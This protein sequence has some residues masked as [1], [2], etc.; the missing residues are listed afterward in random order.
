MKENSHFDKKSLKIIQG[1][2]ASWSELAKDCVCFANGVGGE[3]HIGV[4]DDKDFPASEQIITTEMVE[5]ISKRIPA[6]TLNV[7]IAPSIETAE[8]GGQYINLRVL[9]SKQTV[10]ST[11]DGRYYMRVS[12][13]CKPILPDE[14][15]RLAAEKDAFVWEEK[16]F[17]KIAFTDKDEAKYKVFLTDVLE[18]ERVSG[19][20]KEMSGEEIAEHYF[21]Q[22][23]GF[24]TNLGIL[25]LGKRNQ[26]ATLHYAP[27]IQFIK[28]NSDEKKIFKKV[29]DDY[30]L[31]PKELIN[32]IINSI[33]D[34]NEFIEVS[35]GIFRRNIYHYHPEVIRELFANALAHRN[36]TMR[37]DIF[38]NLYTDKLEIHSPG[39]LPLG[40]TPANILTK[41]VQRNTLLA[42]LMYDLKLME[43]EGS[44]YDKVYELLLGNAKGLPEVI[45]G[46]DRVIVTLKKEILDM[47]VL[48]LMDKTTKELQLRQREL[49]CLGLIAQKGGLHAIELA[50]HLGTLKPNALTSWLGRLLE[51]KILLSKGKTKATL[52]YVNP[53]FLKKADFIE[54]TNLKRIE[55]H[56]LKALIYE[57]LKRYPA[58]SKGEIHKRI[59]VDD[60]KERA[61]KLRLDEMIDSGVIY[62]EGEKK[63][64]K[65]FINK[66][67]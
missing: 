46:D 21:L 64:T 30:S 20:V 65:Y 25:W 22:Q 67:Q 38:I 19:F 11:T 63:G 15:A 37:G 36:Y 33:P 47:K 43:K 62:R 6:M 4:E 16:V 61:L 55:P 32:E 9:R 23:D 53:D 17:K 48:Q 13:E 2:K 42:K 56:T 41:S 29:W 59:G 50:K 58:S 5:A 35:D 57:D 39:L 12:D 28:Y 54:Q 14:L 31:N 10:A 3:I 34:W 18:S 52:Y 51:M 60:V 26:R 49:I 7:G 40:V 27:S 1:S 24:L 66:K 45:E 8:N 44:G